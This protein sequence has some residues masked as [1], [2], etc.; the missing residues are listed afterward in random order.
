MLFVVVVVCSTVKPSR[1]TLLYRSN[2]TEA[3]LEVLHCFNGNTRE[4]LRHTIDWKPQRPPKSYWSTTYRC[5]S[6][7]QILPTP[8]ATILE[9]A[10]K[11][12]GWCG[13]ST[14]QFL[15]SRLRPLIP[16]PLLALHKNT[17]LTDTGGDNVAS[18]YSSLFCSGPF[19]ETQS[20]AISQTRE[21]GFA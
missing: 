7:D 17:Q 15:P 12:H 5:K 3:A 2:H 4:L 8:T 18:V 1:D 20:K 16:P 10:P 13:P 11:A 6:L 19:R 14:W 21:L 9:G